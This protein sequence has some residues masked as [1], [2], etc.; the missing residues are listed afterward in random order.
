[1]PRPNQRVGREDIKDWGEDELGGV[2]TLMLDEKRD[3]SS[4]AVLIDVHVGK[5]RALG[6]LEKGVDLGR[7]TLLVLTQLPGLGVVRV[8][9]LTGIDHVGEHDFVEGVLLGGNRLLAGVDPL[10]VD[11]EICPPEEGKRA[12]EIF[13]VVPEDV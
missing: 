11:R 3:P 13:V 10:R 6:R 8:D 12:R 5:S 2:L 7:S 4:H 1:M 9:E